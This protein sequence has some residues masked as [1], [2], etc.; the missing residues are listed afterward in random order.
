MPEL[1]LCNV[2]GNLNKK[3]LLE[4]IS[5]IVHEV[6]HDIRYQEILNVLQQRERLGSTA[7]GHGVAIPH[8]RVS[9]LEHPLCVL[10]SLEKAIEF[11]PS[12]LIAV[13]IVFGLLVPENADEEHLKILATLAEQLKSKSY[14]E[15]LRGA[16]TSS[17][18]YHAA[19]SNE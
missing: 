12:E 8:G 1:T 14:R 5:L 16:K 3:Q 19:I 11:D 15:R 6:N 13:D 17:E 7:I 2:S 4:K 9:T 18:L 10:I